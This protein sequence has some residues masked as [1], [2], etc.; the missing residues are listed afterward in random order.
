MWGGGRECDLCEKREWV[1]GWVGIN[2]CVAGEECECGVRESVGVTVALTGS[3]GGVP[4]PV[5]RVC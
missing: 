1:G 2:K 3:A 5:T 4:F